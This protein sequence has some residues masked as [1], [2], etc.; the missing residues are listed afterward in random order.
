MYKDLA[1]IGPSGIV[2]KHKEVITG[3]ARRNECIIMVRPVNKL[4]TSLIAE[5][6]A[7][8]DL[9]VKGKS[10]NW[11][12]QAGFICCDQKFSKLAT[13]DYRGIEMRNLATQKVFKRL[14]MEPQITGLQKK[15]IAKFNEKIKESIRDRFAKPVPLLI[16]SDRLSVLIKEKMLHVVSKGSNGVIHVTS[17]GKPHYDFLLIPNAFMPFGDYPTV[18]QKHKNSVITMFQ[19]LP[20]LKQGYW[21][22]IKDGDSFEEMLVLAES[23]SGVPLTADYDLFAVLPSLNKFSGERTTGFRSVANI[24]AKALAQKERRIVYPN[25]GR[26]SN[27]TR[28]VKREINAH[29]GLKKVIHHGCELDN[30]V[31]ELDYPITVFTPWDEVI[32]VTNQYELELLIKD[33]TR[34]GY[35]FY[36][37]R[38]W[39]QKGK[40]NSNPSPLGAIPT[41]KQDY[42]FDTLIP[43]GELSRQHLEVFTR[44]PMM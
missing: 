30:P 12:P 10:S 13:K 23:D 36:A 14:T 28:T 27:L 20:N 17:H 43:E 3:T 11:G 40:V 18:Y 1:A 21:V 35:I 39:S 42:Q 37:N 31:T 44:A 19:H 9:H 15:E 6:Y 38:L 4:S 5:G 41:Y 25:S 8:K 26:I 22:M 29:I 24:V 16:S 33:A 32:G 2:P 34:L 7:T